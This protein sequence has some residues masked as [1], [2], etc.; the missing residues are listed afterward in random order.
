MTNPLI[1]DAFSRRSC[2]GFLGAAALAGCGRRGTLAEV[3]LPAT[4][5]SDTIRIIVATSR[6]PVEAPE[7]FSA[8][9]DFATNFADFSISIPKDRKPGKIEYPGA[10]PDPKRHFLVADAERL[11][12]PQGYV[13]AIN[14]AAAGL[15]GDEKTGQLIVH[16]FNTNFAESLMKTAQLD[17]DLLA[18]GV[19]MM[20][21]WPSAAQLLSYVED[22]ENALF[23]REALAETLRLVGRSSLRNYNLVAHSM[24]TF[25]TMETLRTM[26]MSN[27]RATLGKIG[28]VILISADPA[29]GA[30]VREAM[31]GRWPGRRVPVATSADEAEEQ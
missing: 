12:G 3:A 25:L 4:A 30:L 20:F 17:H 18:P 16:G 2:L 1:R 14:N 31:R 5:D 19:H 23:S 27:E 24:G 13:K 8:E 22:R 6:A 26:A 15:H 29:V 21:T 7:F 9:R 11:D 10:K 28:A